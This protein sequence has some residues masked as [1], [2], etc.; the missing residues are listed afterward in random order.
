MNLI[1]EI[2]ANTKKAQKLAEES[3]DAKV[4][5]NSIKL[6]QS[7]VN[8][9]KIEE[10]NRFFVGVRENNDVVLVVNR[11]TLGEKGTLGAKINKSNSFQYSGEKRS[12]VT[13]LGTVFTLEL[14][15]NSENPVYK[16]VAKPLEASVKETELTQVVDEIQA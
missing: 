9:A 6:S 4:Y 7:F 14:V 8:S 10:T 11:G 3:F 16:F 13:N 12:I 1:N 15:E 2:L 5:K